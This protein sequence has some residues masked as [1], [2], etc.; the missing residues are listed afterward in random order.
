MDGPK[1]VQ[2]IFVVSK[3]Y[4]QDFQPHISTVIT[5]IYNQNF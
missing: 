5:Q 1:V 2:N 3:G 4:T